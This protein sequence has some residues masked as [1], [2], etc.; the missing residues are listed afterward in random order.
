MNTKFKLLTFFIISIFLLSVLQVEAQSLKEIRAKAKQLKEQQAAKKNSTNESSKTEKSKPTEQKQ[1][2]KQETASKPT[3]KQGT[4]KLEFDKNAVAIGYNTLFLKMKLDAVTGEFKLPEFAAKNLPEA[5]YGANDNQ[6]KVAIALKKDGK[7]LETFMY[8]YVRTSMSAGWKTAN[9]NSK[10]YKIAEPGNYNLVLLVDGEETDKFEFEI[11]L[12]TNKN[13]ISGLFINKP[14]KDL[15]LIGAK[16][17]AYGKPNLTSPFVFNFYEAVLDAEG[18]YYS[19]PTPLSVRLM[20]REASGEDKYL[21]GYLNQEQSHKPKW[22]LTDNVFF[23]LP[24]E[25]YKY[26]LTKDVLS[27]D[28]KYY[29]DLFYDGKRYNYNFEVKAGAIITDFSNHTESGKYFVKRELVGVPKYENF[30]LTLPIAGKAENISINVKTG[31]STRGYAA[32]K[33]VSFTDGQQIKAHLY[34]KDDT[35]EHF[36]YKPVEYITTLKENNKIIAQHIINRLFTGSDH[37][38]QLVNIKDLVVKQ[39]YHTHVFMEALSKLSPG[40]HKLEL[41]YEIASGKDTKLIGYR[42]LTY[43]SVSKNPK[44]TEH[45]E[46][47]K[48]QVEMTLAEIGNLRFL[49]SASDDWAYFVNNCGTIVWIRQDEYKEYHI[50]SGDK[51]KINRS[52]FWEQW[53]F[54]TWKWNPIEEFG[55]SYKTEY[56]LS[57]NEIAMLQLK[58]IPKETIEKLNE[59]KDKTFTTRDA[60]NIKVKTLIGAEAFEKHGELIEEHASI[61]YIKICK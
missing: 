16:V 12:V 2:A 58:R 43:K 50:F 7:T 10:T 3:Q 57:G 51:A 31:S 42:K 18:N 41:I 55:S 34:L 47:T 37:F 25:R 4:T 36:M 20:K 30:R 5:D 15:G 39:D 52:G 23:A 60:F 40:A 19:D 27:V 59:I 61:D 8:P 56:I 53:N 9:G 17:I 32:P 54:R 29:V 22:T 11:S 44:Y 33:S 38:S 35:K 13:D 21:G 26:V 45:A 48:E 46:T 49:N 28:G 14:Y 6:H 1:E 24:G